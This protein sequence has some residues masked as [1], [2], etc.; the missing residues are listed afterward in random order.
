MDSCGEAY[1]AALPSAACG[2][3]Q[4]AACAAA[5]AASVAYVAYAASAAY[6][7]PEAQ[8]LQSSLQKIRRVLK[9]SC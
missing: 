7:D 9:D 3:A 6:L 1:A 2:V 5:F 8:P 4:A